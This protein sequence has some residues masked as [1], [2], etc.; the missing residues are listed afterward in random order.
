MRHFGGCPDLRRTV[1]LTRRDVLQAGA[2]GTVGLSLPGLLSARALAAGTAADSAGPA[3][4]RAK[5]CIFL[6]MWGGPSQLETFDPKPD[7]P[8]EIRGEFGPIDTNVPGI[9]IGEHFQQLARLAD[10]FALIRSLSHDDPAHL[11]SGHTVLTGHLP[12]VNKSDAEPPSER[13]TPH[14][15]SVL[16]RLRNAPSGLPP[17]VTMPWLAYHPAAPGG[18]APGQHGGWLGRQYDPLL[19]TGDP[20]QPGWKVEALSLM[21]GLT[22]ERLRN[23]HELLKSLDRQ[24]T[25]L[26]GAGPTG[27]VGEQQAQAIDLL[28]SPAVRNAFE[29][30]QEP[31]PVRD[32][33]GRNIHG[34]CV[35]LARRLVEHG[36]PLVSVNWHDDG[37]AFW[38][39]HGNNF[40]RL[41]NDLI[42]PADRALS[43]LIEDLDASGRLSE[44][45]IV[46]V[47]EFGRRPQIS[48][49]NAGREHWPFCYNGLLAGGG[50]RGGTVYGASDA[51]AAYPADAPCS[52]HDLVATLY[53][54]LGVPADTALYD[55]LE[56]PHQLYA[57]SPLLPLFG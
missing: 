46:W 17:F 23:S 5:A 55:R 34:Q 12:P 36:V 31:E 53:H 21:D 51:H 22:P 30:D 1:R 38:D 35:L 7:A 4:G 11:S 54:A 41:K 45:L 37:Q 49:N 56:R 44:T 2:L 27:Q 42:P 50:V 25:V 14:I 20:S 40:N 8:A 39:T 33:Y 13:D 3:F 29:L 19:I 47:G 10:K 15:G 24:K 43:A 9:R 48:Q 6:F 16:S 52:P 28:T 57:G 26:D 18:R 32:R